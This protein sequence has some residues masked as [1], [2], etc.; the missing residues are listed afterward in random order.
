MNEKKLEI[1]PY[2][3][4]STARSNV[5]LERTGFVQGKAQRIT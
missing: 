4:P 2:I 1:H 3:H 5:K